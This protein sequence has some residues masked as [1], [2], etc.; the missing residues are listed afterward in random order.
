MAKQRAR[1]IERECAKHNACVQDA[2]RLRFTQEIARAPVSASDTASAGDEKVTT[3]DHAL[4]CRSHTQSQQSP[5]A[6]AI[7]IGVT[8]SVSFCCETFGGTSF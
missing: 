3:A 6:H 1:E 8:K 4:L 2:V 5:E 7:A